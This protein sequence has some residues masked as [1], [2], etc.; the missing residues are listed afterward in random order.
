MDLKI[1]L[2]ATYEHT[3]KLM[4]KHV[5]QRRQAIIYAIQSGETIRDAP[6]SKQ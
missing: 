2:D 3:E 1:I 4:I 6:Y 5:N